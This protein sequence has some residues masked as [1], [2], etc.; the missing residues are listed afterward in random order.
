MRISYSA[1]SEAV[2]VLTWETSRDRGF[3]ARPK[4][5]MHKLGTTTVCQS[6]C[7]PA[8]SEHVVKAEIIPKIL[9]DRLRNFNTGFSISY[10]A[11]VH[12]TGYFL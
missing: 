2:P 11:R 3:E 10:M 5:G 9:A 12:S 6:T 8:Y 4:P 1:S 7:Q